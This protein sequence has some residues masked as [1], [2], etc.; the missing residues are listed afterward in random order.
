MQPCAQTQQ[1]CLQIAS[2]LDDEHADTELFAGLAAFRFT[3][4]CFA[5][6]GKR[7]WYATVKLERSTSW[8]FVLDALV[9]ACCLQHGG[10]DPR[11][12]RPGW[13]IRPQRQN[14]THFGRAHQKKLSDTCIYIHIQSCSQ[15]QVN[16]SI[17]VS[18]VVFLV[19][20]FRQTSKVEETLE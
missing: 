15:T 17:V 2:F 12:G 19:C 11:L 9:P 1:N 16:H 3:N 7:R 5:G 8:F 6:R 14:S 4:K 20:I 18:C 13:A 10:P